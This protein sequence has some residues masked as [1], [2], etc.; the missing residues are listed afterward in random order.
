M[1][2]DGLGGS[3]GVNVRAIRMVCRSE[4][5]VHGITGGSQGVPDE[6]NMDEFER[7]LLQKFK[8]ADESNDQNLDSREFGIFVHPHRSAGMIQHIIREQIAAYDKDGDGFISRKEYIS[9]CYVFVHL[10][11]LMGGVKT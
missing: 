7:S 4:V 9:T 8:T 2:I 11:V 1:W 5:N 10:C 3:E 6:A